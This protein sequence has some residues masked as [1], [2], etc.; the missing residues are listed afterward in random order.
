MQVKHIPKLGEMVKSW[1]FWLII[2]TGI[3]IAIRSLPAWTYYAWGADFG[4]YYGLTSRLVENQQ[5]FLA[6]DGWGSSYNYFP[7]LY[8]VSAFGHWLTGADLMWVMAKIAPVFG[9][10]TVLIFYFIVY[11]LTKKRNIALLSSLFLAVIPFHVYQTSHAAPLTMGHFFMMLSIYF[12]IKYS[13]NYKYLAFLMISTILLIMSHHL[14]TYFYLISLLL[15]VLVKSLETELKFLWKEITYLTVGSALTFSYWFLVATPVSD[16]FM[17][18]GI[19]FQSQQVAVL[20]Y[21]VMYGALFGSYV[22]KKYMSSLVNFVRK[23]FWSDTPNRHKRALA[24]FISSV[25]II[26]SIEFIFLFV[27]FPASGIKMT[28]LAIVYSLPIVFFIGIGC[29]GLEYLKDVENSW[30]FKAWLLATIGSFVYSVVTSNHTLF[31]DRHIEYIAAPLCFIVSVGIIKFIK[32]KVK[33]QSISLN[34]ELLTQPI[35]VIALVIVAGV[36]FS[37]AVA[38]YPV[39]D[40]LDWMDEGISETTAN[41]IGW[42][43]E[44]LDKNTTTIATDLRLSKLLW[45]EEFNSTYQFTRE[46]WFTETWQECYEDLDGDGNHSRVTHILIDDAMRETSV[47]IRLKTNFYMTNESYNKFLYQPFTL[48]Y[49]NATV[50]QNM[51]EIRWTEIYSVNWEF[52]DENLGKTEA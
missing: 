21:V 29:M 4:I 3:A 52:I 26:L 30:F 10:L 6:Y 36:V 37:N 35:K 22:A 51:E 43:N 48:V 39:Y 34:K 41:A 15:I 44:N 1:I 9:G 40:S 46:T 24:Y 38:V 45:A 23:L 8:F 2:V 7:V 31:P 25:I 14:T 19:P 47:N 50:N 12:F 5:I 17:E 32:T 42:M 11:E 28:P 20:F 18:G 16:N 49:R 13:Q 27:S 33:I